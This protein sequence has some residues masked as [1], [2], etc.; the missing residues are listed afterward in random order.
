MSCPHEEVTTD[1]LESG[2]VMWQDDASFIVITDANASMW[3]GGDTPCAALALVQNDLHTNR[4]GEFSPNGRYQA[5][6]TSTPDGQLLHNTVIITDTL[7]NQMTV[8][9]TWD[10]SVH[11]VKGGP[12]WLTNELYLIGQTFPQDILYLSLPNGQVGNVLTDLLKQKIEDQEATWW[13]FSQTDPTTEAY[14]LLLQWWGGESTWSP[15]LL[16]H[17]ELDQVEELP[18]YRARPFNSTN[19]VYGFSPD[20]R[21][22]LVGNPV[23]GSDPANDSGQDYWIRPIDSPNNSFIQISAQ[24]ALGGMSGEGEQMAFIENHN[25]IYVVTFPDGQLLSQWFMPGYVV[26]RLWWAPDGIHLAVWGIDQETG[27]EALFVLT[28]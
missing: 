12:N 17:S 25:S 13:L 22:L 8:T 24:A 18:F 1:N 5:V 16:Y 3:S 23:G 2:Y 6:T 4:K 19:A 9:Y 27:Q 7:T 20:G 11:A 26:D 10:T 15:L 28:P 21:W 14:H